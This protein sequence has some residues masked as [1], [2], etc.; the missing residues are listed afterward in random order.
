L[1]RKIDI[2]LHK[3]QICDHMVKKILY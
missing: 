3:T 1:K 2:A